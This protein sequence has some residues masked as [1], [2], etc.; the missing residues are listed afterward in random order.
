MGIADIAWWARHVL[1]DDDTLVRFEEEIRAR[2][3]VRYC[4]FVSTGRAALT[5]ALRALKTLDGAQ[6]DEVVIPSYTCFSV[7]SSVVKAGLKVRL[8]DVD[9]AT[10]DF[11]PG[12][13]ETIDESRVLAVVATNLYGLPSDLPAITRWAKGRG[14]FVVDDAAQCL[15]GSIDRQA[16]GTWGD[17]GL[18]SLDKGKNITSIDG[19]IL[20]TNSERVAAAI[21][22]QVC[23]LP[24]CAPG[25]SL[26]HIAKLFV[27]VALL[28]PRRYW[29]PNMLPFLGLGTTA[30]RIDYP[31]AQYDGW[32]A[33]MGRRFFA[34]LDAINARRIENAGRLTRDLPWGPY[35]EPVVPN[36]RAIPACLR[37]PMLIHPRYR[38]VVVAALC[39]NGIGATA[40]YP[41][42]ISDV[43]ELRDHIRNGEREV[44]GGRDVAR[45]IV[46]LPTHGYVSLQD[47]ERMVMVVASLLGD[48]YGSRTTA[49]MLLQAQIQSSIDAIG[50]HEKEWNA[51]TAKSETNTV[52][53]TFQW[54]KSWLKAFGDQYDQMFVSVADPSGVVGVAPFVVQKGIMG[55]RS[56]RFLGDGKADYC[57]VLA[58]GDKPRVLDA[59]F[60]ALFAVDERWDVIELNNIPAESSTVE[61]VRAICRRTGHRILVYEQFRCPTLLIRGHEDEALKIFNKTS[62]RRRQHYFERNGP[63]AFKDLTGAAVI[64]YLDGFFEQHVAR[65]AGSKSPSLFLKERNRVFYRELAASMA[66]KGWLLLSVVEF[67]GLPLALHY[68]FDYNGTLLWYKP[69]FD[70]SYAKHSPGLVLLRHLIGYAIEQRRREFDFTIGDE[71]FKSRFANSIRKTVSLKIFRGSGRFLLESLKHKLLTAVRGLS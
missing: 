50:L 71:P 32:M 39:A 27:Y 16:S 38:D 4:T 43:P 56:V 13:L 2:F 34:R 68:G 53:Q 52:F 58:T 66:D 6:R 51:L 15:G 70:V 36:P 31:L 22:E 54:V 35:L 24:K 10:L 62:L 5:L 33:P 47:H 41:T 21:H 55:E 61:L 49:P 3:G 67:N 57:D 1:T 46:T 19:G 7:A 11:A 48:S 14:V 63:L 44:V 30:C 17:V 42:A 26:I 8:A 9:P 18:Y 64:P 59:I 40:S 29:L 28:H 23:T 60:D 20:V 12:A 69:S 45:R 65:W 25:E 37:F